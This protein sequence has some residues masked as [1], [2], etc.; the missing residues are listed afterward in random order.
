MVESVEALS[1]QARL[2]RGRRASQPKPI[3]RRAR[4]GRRRV[5]VGAR[6]RPVP[7]TASPRLQRSAVKASYAR[8]G[9]GASWG[10]HGTYL[11]REGAQREGAKGRGFDAERE[12]VDLTATLRGWQEAGDRRLWKF[13]VS[14]EHGERL[15]LHA[16]T[17]AL[18]AQ[19]EKDLGTPLEWAAID[20][21]NTDNAHVHLLVRGRA[22]TGQPLDISPTYLTNGLRSRSQELATTVLGLRSEREH[23]VT[24]G[25][26]VERTQFTEIDRALLR[27][28]DGD[29]LVTYEG[30]RP[31]TAQGQEIRVQEMRRLQF[32]VGLGVAEKVGTRTWRLAPEMESALREA[33][34][35]GDIIK[36]RARHL[37]QLSDPRQPLVVTRLNAGVRVTG[38]VVGTGLADELRD[39]RYLLLEGSDHRLHYIPQPP[40]VERAR[41][42]GHL[43]VG[44]IVTLSG[45]AIERGGRRRMVQTRI[46]VHAVAPGSNGQPERA[47]AMPGAEGLPRMRRVERALGR[48]VTVVPPT[49]GL[50]YRGQMVAYAR[51]DDGHRY[52]VVNT[53]RDLSAFRTPDADLAPGRDIRAQAQHADDDRR[54]RLVWRLGDDERQQK[55]ERA[56]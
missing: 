1:L 32:L 39:W 11:A 12:D 33:Q 36:S 23:V 16:H 27:R 31:R 18:G 20:H 51:G 46:D 42:A 30:A 52:A 25:L 37:P 15:D 28:A 3:H 19:M 2:T 55:R 35:S 38:R 44:D 8:N 29:R 7:Q 49:E 21:H 43:R 13:I 6:G 4:P 48:T 24:R 34:V 9:R 10:A 5:R 17:R 56:K 45:H 41:G 40:A 54:R 53:G 14:P 22:A 47:R 50:I 26:A